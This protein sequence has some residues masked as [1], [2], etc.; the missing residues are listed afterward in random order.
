MQPGSSIGP[1]HR[2]LPLLL[3]WAVISLLLPSPARGQQD[4]ARFQ[5]V[6]PEGHTFAVNSVA[7][8]PDGNLVVTAGADNTA[9]IWDAATGREIRAL[10]GHTRG[11]NRARFTTDGRLVVTASDDSTVRIW[12]ALTGQERSRIAAHAGGVLSIAISSD[13][14]LIASAG[15]DGFARVWQLADGQKVAEFHGDSGAMN[16]VAFSADGRYLA[17]GGWDHSARIWDLTFRRELLALTSHGGAVTQVEFSSDGSRLLTAAGN[18][19][20]LRVWSLP[21]GRMLQALQQSGAGLR[22]GSFCGGSRR[23][24]S[25]GEDGVGRIWDVETGQVS[26]VVKS[27]DEQLAVVACN[28]DG[29]RLLA[30]GR[31]GRAGIWDAGG[32]RLAQL[33]GYDLK[34]A[35]GTV[36]SDGRLASVI[37][38]DTSVAIWQVGTG[39]PI[40]RLRGYRSPIATLAF[41]PDGKLLATGGLDGTVRLWDVATGQERQSFT[42]HRGPVLALGFSPSGRLLLSGGLD[43]TIKIRDATTGAESGL[44]KA[45]GWSQASFGAD[46]RYVLTVSR[47]GIRAWAV[48]T[49]QPQREVPIA[50]AQ[51]GSLSP[52]GRLLLVASRDSAPRLLDARTGRL[53]RSLRD[54]NGIISGALFS[55]DGR[56]LAAALTDGSVRIWN[57]ATGRQTIALP[58]RGRGISRLIGWV[59]NGRLLTAAGD[60]SIRL[61]DVPSGRELLTRYLLEGDDWIAI[62]PDGRFDGTEAGMRQLHFARGLETASLESFFDRYYVP[63]LTELVLHGGRTT[64][65]SNIQR[66]TSPRP[67]VRILSPVTGDTLRRAALVAIEATD[68][69]GGVEDIRLYHNGALVGGSTRNFG[70]KR[71]QCPASAVCFTVELLPGSN[72]LEAT[73]YSRTRVEAERARVTVEYKG[74]T[75]RAA[76]HILAVG[77]NHYRNPRYNLNYGRADATAFVDSIAAGGDSIFSRVVVDTL[78]DDG[79]T[80]AGLR[81]ALE[82]A[83]ADARPEDVFVFYYAGHGTVEQGSDSSRFFLVPTDVTQM[84]D[85]GQLDSL[86]L[87][88]GELLDLLARIP[89]RKKLM[90]IDACQSGALLQSFARRGA[91]EERAI[92]QLARSSGIYVISATDGDQFASEVE[93]LG[94]GVFTYALLQ[95]I[96]GDH[97]GARRERMV[98]EIVSEAARLIP[99]LSR[100]HRTQPQYPMVFSNGQDFPLVVR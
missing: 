9:R 88:N 30:A 84:S 66:E 19:G 71:D 63:G 80:G 12:D 49:G 20:V 37:A 22:S 94:H 68:K 97:A 45:S 7:F 67:T 34:I 99:E 8:S 5:L 23:V 41:S 31:T 76:L 86:G 11:V 35:R 14:K 47:D 55:S 81:A 77:I 44:I 25:G 92:A 64:P 83:A 98:G 10:I 91:A 16:D 82:R 57:V 69:G 40:A 32:N 15:W 24:A 70:R 4:T 90:V 53:V 78:F 89:A 29:T 54:G 26:A 50:L 13:G 39:R 74:S 72:V 33:R 2:L 52:D 36:S 3:G 18:E 1:K 96:S 56:F 60:G 28:G 73:A 93:Q 42:D 79:A 48:A 46:D 43:S 75:P 95:A 59:E 85:G 6:T 21:D 65:G 87:S 61:W 62:A 58:P 38:S 27:Q 100:Q 17:T 51:G